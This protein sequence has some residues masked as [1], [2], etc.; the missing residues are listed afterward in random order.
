MP[1][2]PDIGA[3]HEPLK[4]LLK[5]GDFFDAERN[6]TIPYKLYY[7]DNDGARVPVIVWSHGYGGNRD[8]AGFIARYIASHGYILLHLTHPGSDS[9]LWEGKPGH[10]WDILRSIK[11]TRE[12]SLNRFGDAPF[13]LDELEAGRFDHDDIPKMMDLDKIGISG[14]SFGALTTQ[15]MAGQKYPDLSGELISLKDRRFRAGIA[16]SPMPMHH[17]SDAPAAEIFGGI[18]IPLFHMTGTDDGSPIE[19]FDYRARLDVYN[20]TGAAD[21]YLMALQDGDHMVYNG[22]RGKLEKNPNRDAHEKII[23]IASLAFWEA[24]LKNNR[25]ALAWLRENYR[26]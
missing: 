19:G 5:R 12:M 8:G 14:H 4:V 7:P 3:D 24:Y 23:K 9:L 16:Y 13:V 10:P 18:D 15:V 21:K 20:H 2:Q 11:I 25:D 22:T 17:I 6:R 1:W 26:A